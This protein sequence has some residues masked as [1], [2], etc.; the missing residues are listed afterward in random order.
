MSLLCIVTAG[1]GG[2]DERR[3]LRLTK[4]IDLPVTYYYVDKSASKISEM[5]KIR[6]VLRSKNWDLVYQEGTGIASGINLIAASLFNHQRFVVSSG[7]P[8]AGY[9]YTKYGRPI[10]D[11]FGVYERLLYASCSGFIGWTPYL[12]GVAMHMG[13]PDAITVEGGAE[14]SVFKPFDNS[15][16]QE[17]RRKYSIPDHHIVCGVAGSLNWVKRQSW[18]Q[19]YELVQTLK[20]LKRD[21]VSMLIVGDG[22]GKSVLEKAIPSHLKSRVIFTGRV[23]EAEVVETINIMDIGFIALV[24]DKLGNFRLSTKLPEYLACG[25]GVAMSPVPGYYDYASAAG[26]SLP[27][28]HPGSE[29]FHRECAAWL[30]G[31]SWDEIND[32][33]DHALSLAQ[34]RFSYETIK[35]K[36]E[37]FVSRV[38][39]S[40][41]A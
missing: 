18:C 32:K 39:K 27:S 24:I 28:S 15:V 38:L 21:D 35:P 17:L 40:K 30:D 33:K 14:L 36:F 6:K 1:K 25:S 41:S 3:V 19:G 8:I 26:W 7:D 5:I 2:Q 10:S 23:S 4:D 29:E 37:T 12:T 31:L 9:F 11:L 20:H 16:K 22:S 13:A 34:S